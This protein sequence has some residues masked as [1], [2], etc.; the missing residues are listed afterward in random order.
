[1]I[2]NKYHKNNYFVNLF[3]RI[4]VNQCRPLK[5]PQFK[6]DFFYFLLKLNQDIFLNYI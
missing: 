5:I 4:L 3:K 2:N 1:M 6:Y